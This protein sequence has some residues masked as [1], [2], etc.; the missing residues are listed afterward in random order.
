[1]SRTP[2]GRG[3]PDRCSARFTA[4][5]RFPLIAQNGN[6]YAHVAPAP[7]TLFVYFNISTRV[8]HPGPQLVILRSRP[9][10]RQPPPHVRCEG[11]VKRVEELY[12]RLLNGGNHRLG[13]PRDIQLAPLVTDDDNNVAPL[14]GYRDKSRLWPSQPQLAPLDRG[15]RVGG[16]D[17]DVGVGYV[18]GVVRL[19]VYVAPDGVDVRAVFILRNES[20]LWPSQS[21]VTVGHASILR[22]GLQVAILIPSI[23]LTYAAHPQS[24]APSGWDASERAIPGRF[25]YNTASL[26]TPEVSGDRSLAARFHG[27]F[28]GSDASC[29]GSFTTDQARSS[30][31]VAMQVANLTSYVPHIY[32]THPP[33]QAQSGWGTSK[34]LLRR[35]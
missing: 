32:V 1:M 13:P 34:S 11:P 21:G 29:T 6:T 18:Q 22:V 28:G 26:L 10:T 12:H 17:G 7:A 23:T 19:Q 16:V 33:S 14:T 8:L 20:R 15:L 25:A 30:R 5:S 9:P 24:Q 27:S 2:T 3:F 31:P 35:K 4:L